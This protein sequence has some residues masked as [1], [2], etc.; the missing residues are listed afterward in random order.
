MA[1]LNSLAVSDSIIGVITASLSP[2][3]DSESL[4]LS[5][6]GLPGPVLEAYHS[7]GITAMFP[8]QAECLTTGNVLGE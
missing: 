4:L 3:S 5:S 2:V 6:W 8:W 1:C 7:Q